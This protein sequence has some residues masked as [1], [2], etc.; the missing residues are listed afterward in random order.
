MLSVF[1]VSCSG[2]KVP[3]K[4]NNRETKTVT[5]IDTVSI[6][7]LKN[8]HYSPFSYVIL[9][10][11]LS[12]FDKS[13]HRIKKIVVNQYN[14]TVA[15]ILLPNSEDVKNFSI[16]EIAEIERGFKIVVDWGGGNYFYG[17]EFYFTFKDTQFYLDSFE[18]R[19]YTQEPE[20][21]TKRIKK[22]SPLI[23]IDKFDIISYLD[24]E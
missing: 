6:L 17:R 20:K 22:I 24:N 19:S 11:K 3:H 4:S 2:Q 15:S 10:L 8:K 5:T 18:M 9:Q 12:D 21:E 7:R 16:S 14:E 13:G 1:C 23:P